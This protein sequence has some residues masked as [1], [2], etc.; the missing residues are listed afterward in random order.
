M[1]FISEVLF[2][3][4]EIF[5][6]G[7]MVYGAFTHKMTFGEIMLCCLL[8]VFIDRFIDVKYRKGR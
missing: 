3:I 7:G 6:I 8:F 2:M 4:W 1:N 5:I